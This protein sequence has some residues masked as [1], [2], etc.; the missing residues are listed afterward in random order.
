MS[1]FWN[2]LSAISAAVAAIVV[3]AAGVY[4]KGQVAEAK[5]T[6]E[7]AL[8][9][10]I[11]ERYTRDDVR[12]LRRRQIHGEFDNVDRL[13]AADYDALSRNLDQMEFLAIAVEHGLLDFKLVKAVFLDSPA[14]V[15]GMAQKYHEWARTPSD[16]GP[17]SH[18]ARL[19]ARYDSPTRRYPPLTADP[20]VGVP[21]VTPGPSEAV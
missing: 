17:A 13:S 10:Q 19:A 8:L 1:E 16:S 6:R 18:L 12:S 5:R 9:T 7:I 14:R 2:A 15:W 4:A 21:A 3:V 11:Y 20:D